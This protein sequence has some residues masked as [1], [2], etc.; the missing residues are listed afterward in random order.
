M[1]FRRLRAAPRKFVGLRV[2]VF[3]VGLLYILATTQTIQTIGSALAA[4]TKIG[5]AI[6][7]VSGTTPTSNKQEEENG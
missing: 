5:E 2:I 1:M 7:Q 3:I 4:L 6:Q